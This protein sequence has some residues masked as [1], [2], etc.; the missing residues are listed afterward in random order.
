MVALDALNEIEKRY[1]TEVAKAYQARLDLLSGYSDTDN[2]HRLVKIHSAN[3]R[4]AD[5]LLE[6]DRA[7][8]ALYSEIVGDNIPFPKDFINENVM[9]ALTPPPR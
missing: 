1:T 6:L 7:Q 2:C 5:S 4:M 3:Q 9:E 8:R